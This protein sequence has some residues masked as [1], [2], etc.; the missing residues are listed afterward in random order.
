M[1]TP[2]FDDLAKA[3]TSNHEEVKQQLKQMSER[4]AQVETRNNEIIQRQRDL[5]Q[6]L[7]GRG[8]FAGNSDLE[9]VGRRFAREE[10]LQTFIQR[11]AR[12]DTFQIQTRASLTSSTGNAAG[13]VGVLDI[14]HFENVIATLP[15]R[16]PVVRDLLRVV[17]IQSGTVEA[18]HMSSRANNSRLVT[19]G[20]LKPQS[21]I[22]LQK[23]T[24]TTHVIAHHMKA[25]RQILEDV[26]QLIHL[27]DQELMDGLA[28]T[29]EVQLLSGSG[30]GE[31]LSGLVTNSTSYVDQ[32]GLTDQT[33]L[34][35]LGQ[36]ILQVSLSNFSATGIVLHP[37]DWTAI[38]LL[39]NEN[40]EY[41]VGNP[42][43]TTQKRLFGLPVITTTALASGNFLVGD[44]ETAATLY[45]R[46]EARLEIGTVDDDF[47][48]NMVTILAEERLALAVR[49]AAALV[50]GSFPGAPLTT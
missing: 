47:T 48:R 23:K 46:W 34:D 8:G 29:E 33:Q 45:D 27:I 43:N 18:V 39:K 4:A 22:T 10:G 11:N 6:K 40:G 50:Y 30:V 9:T 3:F 41:I 13:S 38:T 15:T 7:E 35:V 20:G 16:R 25:S 32:L 28:L 21:D 1:T 12:M 49:Y 2:T 44:F 5:E 17:P 42:A 19:E 14:P 37:S 26:P 36:A 24:Y 31:N